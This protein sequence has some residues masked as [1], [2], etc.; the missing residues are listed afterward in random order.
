MKKLN[1]I[2]LAVPYSGMEEESFKEATRASAILMSEG[3]NNVFSP[4][5]HCHPMTKVNGISLPGTWAFWSKIDYQYLDWADEMLIL[6]PKGD[7][8]TVF[9]STGVQAEIK[10]CIENNIKYNLII[11]TKDNKICKLP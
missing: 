2:Y 3:K 10:Y 6:V 11:I 5:T 4:I 9:Y 1:K 7:L 8:N